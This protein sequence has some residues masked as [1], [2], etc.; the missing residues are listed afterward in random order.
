[1][2]WLIPYRK[3][4]WIWG[5]FLITSFLVGRYIA[6]HRDELAPNLAFSDSWHVHL[7]RVD[8]YSENRLV[9]EWYHVQNQFVVKYPLLAGV[10][11]IISQQTGLATTLAVFWVAKLGVLVGFAELWRWMAAEKDEQT[12]QRVVGWM[13]FGYLLTGYV[14]IVPYPEGWQLAFTVLVLNSYGKKQYWLTGFFASL[15]TLTRPQGVLIVP[16]LA[17]GLLLQGGLRRQSYGQWRLK[18]IH[19]LQVCLAPTIAWWLWML[20]AERL[21][22]VAFAPIKLQEKFARPISW[23]VPV[24]IKYV[25]KWVLGEK[26]QHSIGIPLLTLQLILIFAAMIWLTKMALDRKVAPEWVWLSWPT[27]WVCLSTTPFSIAR[28]MLISPVAWVV[29][30]LPERWQAKVRKAEPF[31]WAI[32][33]DITVIWTVY[34][35]TD[36][37]VKSWVFYLP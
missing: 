9:R 36:L 29:I 14:W 20:E 27:L 24:L 8:C 4:F 33:F 31:L 23:P 18:F 16:V 22:G 25:D 10:A 15:L 32:F 3:V 28:F 37:G 34:I 17:L 12:A 2:Q 35:F 13:A 26:F 11:R 6:D 21:T 7:C 1:M 19:I 30:Y 5:L